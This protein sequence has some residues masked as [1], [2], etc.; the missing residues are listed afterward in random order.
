MFI[1][2]ELMRPIDKLYIISFDETYISSRICFDKQ[3][4]EVLG[5]YKCVQTVV[6]RGT[7]KIKSYFDNVFF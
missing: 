3:N 7:D 5:P 2:G 4:E 1:K 6:A